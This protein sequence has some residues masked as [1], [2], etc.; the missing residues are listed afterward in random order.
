MTA[1]E[2]GADR[3]L[4]RDGIQWR[5]RKGSD[6]PPLRQ[7]QRRLDSSVLRRIH[8]LAAIILVD[9]RN[10][11]RL[12]DPP[13]AVAAP[14]EDPRFRQSISRVVDIAEERQPVGNGG[15]RR[16]TLPFPSALAQLAAQ[17]V[18]QLAARRGEAPDIG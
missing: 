7:P 9:M 12:F 3:F 1:T 6:P 8:R 10:V 18:D 4:P 5:S 14:A 15:Q 11:E 16:V 2:H 13:R 17:I